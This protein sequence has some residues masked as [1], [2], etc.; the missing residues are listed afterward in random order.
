MIDQTGKHKVIIYG[1]GRTVWD[2]IDYIRLR[3][4]VMGCSDSD[5]GK[6][7]VAD[8]LGLPFISPDDLTGEEYDY[9]LIT[10]VYDNEISRQLIDRGIEEEKVL[11]RKQWDSM[12]FSHCYGEKNPDKTF[13]ILSHPIHLRDGL[14]S[15]L[16]A[17]LEQMDYVEKN[18]YI[19]IV[20]MQSFW[21]QYLDEDKIG[22]E[23]VW[24][25]YYQPLSEYSLEEVYESRNVILGYD[26]NCYKGNYEQK[27][28]IKRMSELY[29]KYIRY[30]PKVIS[31]I[32][33][34][35][36]KRIDPDSK[37]LGVL[38]RGSDMSALKLKNHPIQPTV[39]E[40]IALIH[41]YMSEWGCQRIF[42]STEDAVAVDRFKKEF[43]DIL[44]CTD[45]KRFGDTK[46]T[47]LANINFDRQNDRYLKGLEYLITIELL[48]R[49]DSLLAGIC[50]GSI[51]A[52]IMN[53]GK[54]RHLKMVDKGEY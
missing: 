13:Y 20:D 52:Q 51:C 17:F 15:F 49:C 33:E 43:G 42:L 5:T 12:V 10:S 22:V 3:F 47:W 37:T 53:N 21:N 24:E 48:S 1:L 34:E 8:R 18:R 27:Y 16:F 41:Q 2:M 32:Q 26:D 6:R 54:Y 45:Q 14:F 25:Y 50:T 9:I 35:Y 36:R 46:E 31:L 40:M 29:Q 19:P 39:D 38:F 23:N 28:D 30:N 7:D 4:R 11:K 44:S